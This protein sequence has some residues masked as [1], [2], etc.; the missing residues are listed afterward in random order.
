MDRKTIDAYDVYHEVY[1]AET[2]DFWEQFPANILNSFLHRIKG[3]KVLDLGSG[4]GR[5]AALLRDNGLDVICVDGSQSMVDITS[6]MGFRSIRC[7]FRELDFKPGD[8]DAVW[9]YSSLIHVKLDE[10]ISILKKVHGILKT[11]G[12]L[13]LG[14]I[15]GTGN[16]M[17]SIGG[18][19]FERYFEYYD[20]NKLDK[21]LD[22]SGFRILEV[23]T[24][25]PGN[26]T[27]LNLV[28]ERENL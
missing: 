21:L 27:Y 4:P 19:S 11:G 12:I 9:A 15:E 7:D 16:E 22:K 2:R 28:M 24:Y 6:G 20:G 17:V 23:N 3:R 5:D 10:A 26:H 1:D 8:F 18:S 25:M 13:F 14:L